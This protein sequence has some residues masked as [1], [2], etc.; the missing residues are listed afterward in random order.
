MES[1]ISKWKDFLTSDKGFSKHTISS[2]II[3]LNY[4]FK[5]ISDHT[6]SSISINQLESLSLQD[7]R[8]WL[9]YRKKNN[10]AFTSTIRAIAAVKNFFKYLIK[11]HNFS[12]KSIFNLRTPKSPASLPKALNENQTFSAL[13]FSSLPNNQYSWLIQR[14]KAI[15]YLIYG[16]G[17]RISEALSLKKRDVTKSYLNVLGKGS[18]QRM[19]PVI[20]AVNEMILEYLNECPYTIKED[21]FVFLGKQGK[22]LNPGVFQ[23]HIRN[24]RNQLNL[25]D[26]TTPHAFRHSFATHILTNGG[27]LKSI[28]ELLGHQDLSTTQKYTKVDSSHLL[29]IYN[30]SHPYSNN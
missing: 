20:D 17:L 25:P 14:D 5:F 15:L 7:F 26:S 27:D 22:P 6:S 28:Q 11:F 18:K 13:N 16:C 29:K 3:D 12:N 10:F 23:R 9:A 2:Y 4:F 24:V 1:L 8:A 21:D 30:K 19:L